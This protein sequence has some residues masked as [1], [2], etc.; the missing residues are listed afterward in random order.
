MERPAPEGPAANKSH[1]NWP[2]AKH[3]TGKWGIARLR[4]VIALESMDMIPQETDANNKCRNGKPLTVAELSKAKALPA[5]FLMRL[6][7]HDLP[8]VGV[9]IPYYARD[10]SQIA[11]KR[12]TALKANDGSYWPKGMKLACY[13]DWKLDA[14]RKAGFLFLVEGESDSWAFWYHQL[15]VLGI[16]GANAAKVLTAE[17]LECLDS[18]YIHREPDGGGDSFIE[19]MV[20]RLGELHY[21][22]MVFE[23][24]CPSGIKDPADLHVHNEQHFR[25]ALE[26]C[27]K[28]AI[29]LLSKKDGRSAPCP[30]RQRPEIITAAELHMMPLPDPRWAIPGIVPDGLSLLAGKP[31]LGK[32][33]LALNLAL[34]VATGGTAL[35]SVQV[36][37]GDVLYLALEDTKRRLKSRIEKLL[38]WQA[39]GEWPATLCI[40]TH[41]PRQDKAG[42]YELIEW[43]EEHPG[44]RLII[45]DTWPRFRPFRARGRDNY[46][47]DYQHASELK[48]LADKYDVA[49]QALAH[50]RK[51]DAPDPLDE[52][53]GTLGLTGAADGVAVL[54]RERG[55]HDATLFLT[56]RDIEEREI[57]LRWDPVFALWSILGEAD[58]YR[59]SKERQ[60][61]IELLKTAGE[62]L[63]PKRAADLLGKNTNEGAVRKLLWTMAKAGQIEGRSGKYAIGNSG[64]NGNAHQN[65]VVTAVTGQSRDG[66]PLDA[67]LNGPLP[68]LP[69]LPLLSRSREMGGS[70]SESR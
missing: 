70:R 44:A 69:E 4:L 25:Q 5:E 65:G 15:P 11:V 7:L 52:V 6:G 14:A 55:Q 16:P 46:E 12:R 2:E 24:R 68:R 53:S 35:G 41:W 18:V 47:E 39:L 62:P 19:G 57:A 21:G 20:A 58:E 67:T 45:I 42:L 38:A 10:G 8:G 9:A 50:C 33:W 64:N 54:K 31:K 61:I 56:G 17:H 30:N 48:A 28:A 27:I 13:G 29:P 63:T 22:G 66:E 34:A 40:A 26:D 60:G 51:L 32:S 37:H 59:L 3:P 23:L 49:V 1:D 43:L 36:A